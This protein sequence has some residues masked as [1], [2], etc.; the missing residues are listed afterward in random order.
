MRVRTPLR[1]SAPNS[2]GAGW[3]DSPRVYDE[4]CLCASRTSAR[5]SSWVSA[6]RPS[7]SRCSSAH[8]TVVGSPTCMTSFSLRINT[9]PQSP[10]TSR[11]ASLALAISSHSLVAEVRL[12]AC[13]SSFSLRCS[14]GGPPS[15][16]MRL[17]RL[18]AAASTRR[19][20]SAGSAGVAHSTLRAPIV[21]PTLSRIGAQTSR[22]TC[23][24]IG[25]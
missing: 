6:R 10:E 7:R 2:S 9:A 8:G 22:A 12:I 4:P 3:P 19:W 18:S 20:E 15:E 17:P 21:R 23:G 24:P 1:T 25:M 14:A 5:S 11:A 13:R 16:Q